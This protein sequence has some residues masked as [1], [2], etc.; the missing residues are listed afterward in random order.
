MSSPQTVGDV[1]GGM[2]RQRRRQRPCPWRRGV[3][4]TDPDGTASQIGGPL[5]SD[6]RESP[7][8]GTSSA[9][10]QRASLTGKG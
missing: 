9:Q 6:H 5:E 10:L 4:I 7:S 2:K 3:R 8:H 1:L